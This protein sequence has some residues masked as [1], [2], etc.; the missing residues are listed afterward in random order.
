MAWWPPE[1][2]SGTTGATSPMS[3]DPTRPEMGRVGIWKPRLIKNFQVF[4]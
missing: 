2:S 3:L 4:S 1:S